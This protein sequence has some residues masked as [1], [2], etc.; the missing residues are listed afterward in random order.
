MNGM[1]GT[2][3]AAAALA[4]THRRHGAAGGRRVRR[5]GSLALLAVACR[6]APAA[7][8]PEWPKADPAA[9]QRWQDLRFGLFIHWGPVSL[10]GTE[11][12]WS[13]GKQVPVEE[14]D[15]LYQQFNPV[16]FNADDWAALAKAAGMKYLVLITK[17]HDGFCLWDTRFT[18][19][20]IMHTPFRRDVVQEV[21]AACKRQGLAFGAYY[22]VADWYHPN[23]PGGRGGKQDPKPDMDAYEKYLNSQVEELIT[24]YGPLLTIWGDLPQSY[25][26]RGASMIRRA[27]QLQPDILINNRCGLDGDY[28]ILEQKLGKF[29]NTRPWETC[30]TLGTS[31]SW[32]TNETVKSLKQCVQTLLQC[33]GGDA[34][35]LLNVGPMPT[36]QI[37]PQ[38]AARLREVGAWLAKYGVSVYG[39]RGGPFMPGRGQVSTH[40]DNVVYVHVLKWEAA[41][42]KLPAL[43]RKIV[44]STVLTGGTAAVQQDAQGVTLAVPTADRQE[45]DTIVKLELDGPTQDLAPIPVAP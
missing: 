35:F 34:N 24:K 44:K 5:L 43:G 12:G 40:K 4:N 14:Y 1:A 13:R 10:K 37:E 23:W 28:L 9:V 2:H 31:W 20:N 26:W 3:F 6:G 18:D 19:Y 42:L 39:T 45:M 17:H 11:I 8:P 22:S 7:A 21:A 25:G 15:H 29:N 32:K 41:E 30:M 38:Q 36:G 27:R 16:Q 33:V